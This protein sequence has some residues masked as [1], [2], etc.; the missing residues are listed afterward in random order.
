MRVES[1]RGPVILL[2]FNELAP[3]LMERFMGEGLLPNFARFRAES[4]AYITDAEETPPN[5]EPW[6]QWVTVHSGLPFEEHRIFY[7]GDGPKLDRPCVW[8]SVSASGR[9][10]WICGSMNIRHDERLLGCVLPDPWTDA[11]PP[12]P[13]ALEPFYRFVRQHVLEYTSDRVPLR[14]GDYARFAGFMAGHGLSPATAQAIAR[15]L[16]AERGGP[17]RWRRAALLD[18]L[19]CDLFEWYFRRCRPALST[20]FINSTAHFQH[21]YW[22]NMEPEKF[23]HKPTSKEQAAFRDAIRFGYQQMDRLIG[24]FLELAESG[25]TLVLATALS[26]KPCLLYEARGGKVLH[27]ARD[28]RALLGFAGIPGSPRISPVMSTDFHLEFDCDDDAAEAARRLDA[29]RLGEDRPAMNVEL[30]GRVV[31][32]GPTTAPVPGDAVLSSP[33]TGRA[34]P[35]FQLFYRAE[36]LKSGMHHP[37]GLLWIRLP[38]R[39]RA[40]HAGKVGLTSI[41][42]TLLEM[43]GAP[44]PPSMRGAPL[45]EVLA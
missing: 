25:A 15:Q 24:R 9:P 40:A 17:W 33:E 45:A 12:R 5:L 14:P 19:Q 11:V 1:R 42:P 6:I 28:P 4:H 43:L 2:E 44:R 10:V 34:A 21:M 41:A 39:E 23:E 29:L 13:A 32:T 31:L 16:L 26:Q 36:G 8:D 35:F 18:K 30:S 3:A 7:L 27:R 22:R 20:F 38:S 37:D